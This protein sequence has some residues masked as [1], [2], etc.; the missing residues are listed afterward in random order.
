MWFLFFA[1]LFSRFAFAGVGWLIYN[2]SI[3]NPSGPPTAV[4]MQQTVTAYYNSIIGQ[5]GVYEKA[6]AA[7]RAFIQDVV[8]DAVSAARESG[9]GDVDD[10]WRDRVLEEGIKRGHVKVDADGFPVS[11][12]DPTGS[13]AVQVLDSVRYPNNPSCPFPSP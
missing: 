9:K 4:S 11:Q 13:G 12:F 6:K 2:I 5:P 8:M 10:S 1:F 3:P 7:R